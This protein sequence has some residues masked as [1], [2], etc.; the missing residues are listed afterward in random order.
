MTKVLSKIGLS[1]L[2]LLLANVSFS[3]IAGYTVTGIKGFKKNIGEVIAY[4]K[5]HPLPANFR[6]ELREE[7]E[8][9]RPSM[10]N[11]GSPAVSQFGT[12]VD[13]QKSL[14]VPMAPNVAATATQ[15]IHSNFLAIWGSY[16]ANAGRESPYT[17]PDNNGDVGTTQVIVTANCRMKVFT[18]PTVVQAASTTSTGTSTTT[19]SAVLNVDLN[20]FFANAGLGISSMS[21]PHVRFDRLTNRWFVT[22][23][24]VN[25]TINNYC[26]VAI[27]SG[28]TI[29]ASSD[30]T[31]YYFSQTQT[32]GL[33][34]DFYDYP[35]LGIDK[36]SL[37][38]GGNMFRNQTTFTGC[39]MYVINKADLI[40]GTLTVT[41]FN[42][43]ATSTNMYTPQGVHNDDPAIAAGYFIGASQTAYGRLVM[44][45]ITYSGTTASISS[46]II[47]TIPTAAAPIDPPTKGG[48]AIDGNDR[49]CV[50][51]MIKKNKIT[52][53]SSL[54]TAYG[55]LMTSA[56]VGS[57][58][59]DRDGAFWFEITTL[60]GTPTVTQSASYYQAGATVIHYTYPAI[61]T[62]GQGHSIMTFTSAGSTKFA[63]ASAAGRYRTDVAGTFQASVDITA[64][65]SAYNAAANR[66]GDYAQAAVDPLDDQTVW[67]FSEYAPT[68]SAWGLRAAQFKAPAPSV[69][70]LV[71]VPA[72]MVSNVTINGTSVNNTE[73]FDPGND[74]GGPGYNRIAVAVTGGPTAVTVSN[75][76]FISPTQITATLSFAS[77]LAQGTYTLKVTN[78]D[79]QF[80]T[81]TFVISAPLPINLVSFTGRLNNSVVELNWKTA[82]EY[83]FKNYVVEKSADGSNFVNF[84]EVAPRGNANTAADYATVD[85]YPYPQYSYYRLKSVNTDGTFAYSNIVKIKTAQRKLSLTRL[86]PNPTATDVTFE[87]Y[88][89]AAQAI[90]VDVYDIAGKKMLSN[91]INLNSGINEKQV[92]LSRVAAGAYFIQFTDAN[93]NIVE[94]VKVMKQ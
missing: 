33:S 45:R 83:N 37:Y 58:G 15:S 56:G 46:D 26:A 77:N 92:S 8:G 48:I 30:F 39:N 66:W 51:A 7:L 12:L 10:I 9:P 73:F 28:P 41:A 34:N 43:T 40:A 35:T 76:A 90:T 21:D 22:M 55:S 91:T 18:K 44:R 78:P 11:A 59:G 4:E 3:Q 60:T 85:R 75:V 47:I 93:H 27:S 89:D 67:T 16:G 38:I 13:Q 65:G 80:T 71:A 82:S 54:W 14:H 50:A 53:T 25:H 29:T 88:A 68:T 49:R 20:T 36:N 57:S 62:T 42:H 86:F 24:E 87:M 17:P 79:G 61:A 52:G 81:N 72:A 69:P 70:V 63:Q 1:F 2:L 19:L 64:T 32:G 84:A 23:I 6:A 31:I 5:A 74:V 94:K